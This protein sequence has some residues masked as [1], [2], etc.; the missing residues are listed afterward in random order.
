MAWGD[1]T[2][3]PEPTVLPLRT[4]RFTRKKP[5]IRILDRTLEIVLPAYFG[6]QAWTIPVDDV[7]LSDLNSATKSSL[8]FDGSDLRSLPR[9]PYFFTTGIA[10]SPNLLPLFRARRRIP[11]LRWGVAGSPNFDFP[12]SRREARSKEGAV[13]DGVLLRVGDVRAV[14]AA[15]ATAGV[16]RTNVP[17][18]WLRRHREIV[19][20]GKQREVLARRR[21]RGR[22]SRISAFALGAG[23]LA[24]AILES[25]ED[26]PW[27]GWMA[28]GG[29][30][31]GLAV[32][33]LVWRSEE[34]EYRGERDG[35]G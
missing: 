35:T 16:E 17:V 3:N 10:T 11:R 26:F 34:R 18:A 7:A 32:Q 6:D 23:L 33:R 12:F 9:I 13:V 31:A 24:G 1:A 5:V 29:V 4:Y 25:R 27:W 19:A 2:S 21:G 22:L 30:A 20:P 28:L 8:D 14:T 15:L